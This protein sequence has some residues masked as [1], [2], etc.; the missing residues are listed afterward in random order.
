MKQ[1]SK[2]AIYTKTPLQ[3]TAFGDELVGE[4]ISGII[5]F[6]ER[7]Q[8][9]G[10]QPGVLRLVIKRGVREYLGQMGGF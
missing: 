8:R 6:S 4:V 7:W 10:V 3:F 1:R 5:R 9:K 2:R